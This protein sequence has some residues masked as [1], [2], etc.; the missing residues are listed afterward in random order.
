METVMIKRETMK[1]TLS[2]I[3]LDISWARLSVRYF[4]KSRSWLHQKLDGINSNGGEGGFSESEK[5]E[6]RL[7]L[8]DLS[9]RINAAADRI[10]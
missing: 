7:A 6:L 2:D 5:A 9:A 8:K 10:E 4:G 3:L 1:Q